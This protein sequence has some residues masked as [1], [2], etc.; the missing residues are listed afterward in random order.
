SPPGP[1]APGDA[2]P[3]AA[4]RRGPIMALPPRPNSLPSF[5]VDLML[6]FMIGALACCLRG[7]GDI[8]NCQKINDRDWIRPDLT[9][10][11]NGIVAD[12]VGTIA[13]S[14]LGTLGSSTYSSSVGMSTAVGVT[15]RVI[16]FWTGGLLVVLSL[17]P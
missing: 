10:I 8:T 6:P 3:G 13:A 16:G 5:S 2:H 17:F 7:M 12:G 11:R 14:F 4:L 1:P 9:S 15:A